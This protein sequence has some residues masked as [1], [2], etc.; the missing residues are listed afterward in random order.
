MYEQHVLAAATQVTRAYE[1]FSPF[2][3]EETGAG[4]AWQLFPAL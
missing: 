2:L 1:R 4:D 3:G